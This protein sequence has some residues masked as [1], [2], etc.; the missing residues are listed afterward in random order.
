MESPPPS[1]SQR[2]TPAGFVPDEGAST[3][4]P[5]DPAE[6]VRLPVAAIRTLAGSAAEAGPD[7]V[8]ALREAGR[9]T[10]EILFEK[11]GGDHPAGELSPDEF[12][13]ALDRALRDRGL[14]S[15]G[16]AVLAPGVA[17][18][19]LAASP[20]SR[21]SGPVGCPLACG[22]IAGLL[23]RV[24]GA[25][26]AVMEVRCASSDGR[27]PCRFLAASPARLRRLHR[28]LDRGEPLAALLDG[29]EA[30]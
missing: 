1:H 19:S 29:E 26:V 24:A 9:T 2:A 17:A 11:V 22:W 8:R 18:L 12:V 27:G 20:E 13:E 23:S 6:S 15:A 14:G 5:P 25:P 21:S 7:A 28:G 10:G 16:Y 3:G 30:T 4:G